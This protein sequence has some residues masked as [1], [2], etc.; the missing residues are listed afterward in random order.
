M[1]KMEVGKRYV[2]Y[3]VRTNGREAAVWIRAGVAYLNRD[4]SMNVLLDVLPIG[5][6]LHIR[7]APAPAAA[8]KEG[9]HDLTADEASYGLHATG[10]VE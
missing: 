4:G 1:S 9:P 3:S 7:E 6:K 2:V 10:T 5:G 8:E